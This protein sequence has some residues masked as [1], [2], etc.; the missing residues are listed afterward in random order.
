MKNKTL[1]ISISL[2]LILGLA[3][4][5]YWYFFMRDILATPTIQEPTDQQPTGFKPLDRPFDQG[6]TTEPTPT[7]TGIGETPTTPASAAKLPILRLLS[8]TPV[9]GYGASSTAATTT[10][11]WVDRGRG[12]V[13]EA[14]YRTSV[15][16]TISNTVVPRMYES[17]W[18]R[19]LTAFIGTLFQD[20]DTA[21]SA[22][23]ADLVK[24]AITPAA[25]GTAQVS[26][27]VAFAPYE[28]RGSSLPTNM[29]GYA[30]SPNKSRI[31]M[32]I[33]ENGNGVGYTASFNGTGMTKI[34]TTPVTQVNVEWPADNI[35][36]ITTKGSA[37]HAG[38]MYF[39]DP[40]SGVWTRVLGPSTGL[41]AVVSRDAKHVLYSSTG[42]GGAVL[43]SIRDVAKGTDTDAVIRTLADKCAWGNFYKEIVY[44]GVPAQL[45]SATYPDAWYTGRVV[46][47]DKVWQ[48]SAT[49]GN[50]KMLAPIIG[51]AD[52]A[53]DAFNMSLD[54]R[55]DYLFFMN[56][57]DLS[58]WSLD[59]VRAD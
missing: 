50:A 26:T 42:K 34:F 13:Y 9:G 16:T 51:Q 53:I 48:V 47:T 46:T 19:N 33:N 15:I 24:R 49:T 21:S 32:L 2:L 25:T 12:N 10:V 14:N 40:T 20:G 7:G 54:T 29:I 37:S 57:S 27:G 5:G 18:N 11:R 59:L 38:F 8:S 39:V 41:S 23:Y 55:D 44:C 17:V 1:T 31:F 22:V 58:L 3:G 45:T 35:I 28:L 52:R 36:A 6:T 43:T 4:A 30:A 56:K